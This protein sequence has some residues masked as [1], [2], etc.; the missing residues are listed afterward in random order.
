[1]KKL[2]IYSTT[3]MMIMFSTTLYAREENK[4]AM[5]SGRKSAKMD[6]KAE[7]MKFNI[8]ERDLVSDMSINAFDARFEN[9]K[10]VVWEKDNIYDEVMFT[11]DGIRY[12]AF[13]DI[14]SNLVGTTT[15]KTFADLPKDAQ[16]EIKKQ[17]KDYSVDKVIFFKDNEFNDGNVRLY[18]AQFEDADNYFVEL[19]DHSKNKNIILQVNPEGN[20]CFF[21][22]LQKEV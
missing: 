1:M 12:K 10:N 2:V 16:K 11:K 8:N 20:V 7:R 15:D 21:K 19:S 4:M 6:S 5:N 17:F 14:N 13:Y 9:A 3:I 22:E 18:G